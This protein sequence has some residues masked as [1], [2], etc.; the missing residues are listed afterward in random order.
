M[1]TI[2]ARIS[3]HLQRPF[4][5]WNIPY[6]T[7][8]SVSLTAASH[9]PLSL[10]RFI[11]LFLSHFFLTSVTSP[12]SWICISKIWEWSQQR[13]KPFKGSEGR[14]GGKEKGKKAKKRE[15]NPPFLLKDLVEENTG[16]LR[17]EHICPCHLS[18]YICIS[19]FNPP[20]KCMR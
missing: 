19:S 8:S 7:C 10:G 4:L 18:G 12:C 15:G 2:A 1:Q 6:S 13:Q 16:T 14:K 20:D 17:P 5:S 11:C 3:T 9:S